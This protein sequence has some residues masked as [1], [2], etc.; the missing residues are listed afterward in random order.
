MV[1]LLL[2]GERTGSP[3]G[4]GKSYKENVPVSLPGNNFLSLFLD[5]L[6]QCLAM[7]GGTRPFAFAQ[8]QGLFHRVDPNYIHLGLGGPG[9]SDL[10]G[11]I[12][13][14]TRCAS[15]QGPFTA[16]FFSSICADEIDHVFAD[17]CQGLFLDAKGQLFLPAFEEAE[18]KSQIGVADVVPAGSGRPLL[19]EWMPDSASG[20]VVR[21]IDR[22]AVKFTSFEK[23]PGQRFGGRR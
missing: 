5:Q 15:A 18:V 10:I 16:N 13:Q 21:H 14:C 1:D 9:A 22:L 23:L 11:Q 6:N 19:R 12:R 20:A 17:F 7:I 4:L 3:A 2:V 8:D